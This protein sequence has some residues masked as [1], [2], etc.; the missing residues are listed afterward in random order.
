MINRIHFIVLNNKNPFELLY[1]HESKLSH[2][3]IIDYE[4]YATNLNKQGKFGAKSIILA[5]LSYSS[6]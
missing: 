4:Y 6:H 5:L 1:K 2:I 3:R